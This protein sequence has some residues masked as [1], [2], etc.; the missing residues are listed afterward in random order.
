MPGRLGDALDHHLD[1]LPAHL[2]RRMVEHGQPTAGGM[3]QGVA[4]GDHDQVPGDLKARSFSR[5]D[6][7]QGGDVTAMSSSVV[8]R[9]ALV[10]IGFPGSLVRQT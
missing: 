10:L 4:E 3:T 8:R 7:D 2:L 6:D 1:G 5:G 9:T